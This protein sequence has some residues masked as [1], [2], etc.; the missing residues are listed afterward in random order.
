MNLSQRKAEVERVNRENAVRY[1]V[2]CVRVRVCACACTCVCVC[3]CMETG[4]APL[5]TGV[6]LPLD[7]IPCPWLRLLQRM[8]DRLTA[9]LEKGSMS[10]ELT[11]PTTLNY[12]SVKHKLPTRRPGKVKNRPTASMASAPTGSSALD[13]VLSA[14]LWPLA[15]GSLCVCT[16]TTTFALVLGSAQC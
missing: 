3:L 14:F 15:C 4:A 12:G 6:L 10:D 2:V 8:L 13:G 16:Q 5:C 1:A 11:P 9:W 7:G